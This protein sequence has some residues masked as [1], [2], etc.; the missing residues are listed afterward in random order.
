MSDSKCQSYRDLRVWQEAVKLAEICY[1]LM[2]IFPKEELYAMTSQI[3]R[4]SV[5]I[6]ANIAEGYGRKHQKEYIQFLYIAQGS[7][8]E[9][10]THLFIAQRVEISSSEDISP[11]L[12]QCDSVGRLLGGLIRAIETRVSGV[13]CR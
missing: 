4:A 8:K 2:K 12:T 1:R 10:E 9:L 7:L 5:S 11:I 3:R 13:G 6:A